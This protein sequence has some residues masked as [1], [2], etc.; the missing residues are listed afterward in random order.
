MRIE[1]WKTIIAE[2]RKAQEEGHWDDIGNLW[3]PQV[4]Y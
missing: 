3:F 1:L 4:S 2:I